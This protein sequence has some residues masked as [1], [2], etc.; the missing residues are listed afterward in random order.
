MRTDIEIPFEASPEAR[1]ALDRLGR[2]EDVRFSPSNQR[3]VIAAFVRGVVGVFDITTTEH[4]DGRRV[5][6]TNPHLLRS[7]RLD[8]P[9]GIAFLDEDTIVVADRVRGLAIL[10]LAPSEDGLKLLEID[11]P[12]SATFALVCVPG[13][14]DIVRNT[15]G[16]SEVIVC[17]NSDE[18]VRRFSSDGAPAGLAGGRITQH[19]LSAVAGQPV[20]ASSRVV[21]RRWLDVPDG[22]CIS[23]CRRWIAVSNHRH[24]VVMVYDRSTAHD[25]SDP[26]AILRGVSY[27]HGAKFS[28]DAR[29]LFVAD[30][31]APYVHVFERAGQTWGGVQ[32]P[33]CS[34]RVMDDDA[35]RRGPEH[36]EEGGPKGIDISSDGQVLAT[37][38]ECVPLAFFDVPSMLEQSAERRSDWPAQVQYELD[39]MDSA[40]RASAGATRRIAALQASTSYK[41][42]APLRSV[43]RAW[44]R[45]RP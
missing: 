36:P 27:P 15:D 16:S 20:V 9:H 29:H 7:P 8:F 44:L 33:T 24:R 39:L 32:L 2:T 4:P 42:T 3:L 18:P 6:V 37:T 22:V 38:S 13:S 35:F 1:T 31:G 26:L 45:A 17:N 19:E 25:A 14:L 11:P 21:L 34:L 5:A 28:A 10:R 12:D 23:P 43:R 41:V 40:A 30:A